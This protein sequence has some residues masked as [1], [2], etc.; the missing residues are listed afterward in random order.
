MKKRILNFFKQLSSSVSSRKIAVEDA[1]EDLLKDINSPG[2]LM[3]FIGNGKIK[4]LRRQAFDKLIELAIENEDN[5][6][7]QF[8]IDQVDKGDNFVEY[9]VIM[10][11][12]GELNKPP[13]IDLKPL[14]RALKSRNFF[15]KR[16][17]IEALQKTQDKSVEN[18]LL[19]ILKSAKNAELLY[20]AMKTLSSNGSRAAIPDMLKLVEHPKEMV[21]NGA[22]GSLVDGFGAEFL[23]LYRSKLLK[24]NTKYQAFRGVCEFGDRSDIPQVKKRI[25]ERLVYNQSN[26]TYIDYKT[27]MMLGLEFLKRVE[28]TEDYFSFLN[29]LKEEKSDKMIVDEVNFLKKELSENRVKTNPN[30]E[31]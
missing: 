12:M 22:L 31:G 23:E 2:E 24:G 9:W 10:D 4:G 18:A 3:A 16:S 8:I 11:R 5:Q 15:A 27:E 6:V 19:L 29:W 14:L 7:T 21:A 25:K 28:S 26:T 17:V 20:A 1:E 30:H 13:E